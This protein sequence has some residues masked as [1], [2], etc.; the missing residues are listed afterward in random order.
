MYKNWSFDDDSNAFLGN[1][2]VQERLPA[3]MYRLVVDYGGRPSATKLELRADRIYRF[4]NGPLPAVLKEI[5]R[6]WESAQHYRNL[7]FSHKRGL[8]L[9]GPAGCGKTGI[10][11]AIIEDTIA[12]DGLVF[13]IDNVVQF[14]E[15]FTKMRQIEHN[16]RT[17]GILE[18]VERFLDG[19][20]EHLLEVM[21]G[22]TSVGDGILFV[23]TTNQLDKIPARIKHRPSRIDTLIEIGFPG[24]EQRFEYLK[25]LLPGK[26]IGSELVARTHD[27]S[28]AALKELVISTEVYG[29]ALPKA[30]E[31]LRKLMGEEQGTYPAKQ[32]A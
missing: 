26:T 12:N 17:V 28:L 5:D 4:E 24:V 22:A 10:I 19:A 32:E 31:G 27:F 25:K 16:R 20:E 1:H 15:A 13:K 6:F 11:S 8:L 3:G 29:T 30:I 2:Q 23:A 18:D 21:D 9:Y 7:G 14:A